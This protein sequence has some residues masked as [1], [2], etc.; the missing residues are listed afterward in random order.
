MKQTEL[1]PAPSLYFGG[2]LKLDFKK[3]SRPLSSRL[4]VHLVL[5][6]HSQYDLFKNKE[7]IEEI[8]TKQSQTFGIKIYGQSIQRDHIHL[9]LKI[10]SRDSYKKYVRSVTGL[11]SR[12]LK[13]KG[14]WKFRPFTRVL[15]WGKPFQTLQSYITQNEKE[16]LGLI[17]K[18]P[19]TNYYVK[20]LGGG[21]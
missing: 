2:A 6:A 21:A 9:N 20:Q 17:P 4:P 8:I 19:R 7:L 18:K 3:H 16:V 5:K 15:G 13:V 12:K 1:I 11:I 10:H 14:L